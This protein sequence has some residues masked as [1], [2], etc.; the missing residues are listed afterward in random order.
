MPYI[1]LATIYCCCLGGLDCY[2]KHPGM[3]IGGPNSCR[4]KAHSKPWIVR[5]SFK[6][7]T[8]NL[9]G[10]VCGG[11]L[12]SKNLVLTAGHCTPAD[13]WPLLVAIV[14][15]HDI[16]KKEGEQIIEIEDMIKHENFTG[17]GKQEILFIIIRTL[18]N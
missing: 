13:R 14:G 10:Q 5:L 8:Y 1:Y 2:Q 4:V 9:K 3:V 12:I 15:D 16:E 11:T 6:N 7:K 18:I 17:I